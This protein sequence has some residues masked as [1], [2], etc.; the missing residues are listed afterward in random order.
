MRILSGV[1]N[2][3]YLFCDLVEI[4]LDFFELLRIYC[5]NDFLPYFGDVQQPFTFPHPDRF[6]NLDQKNIRRGIS[7]WT[8]SKYRSASINAVVLEIY[9]HIADRH[10]GSY[11]Y[12]S[13]RNPKNIKAADDI[14][15]LFV[16]S[17]SATFIDLNKK[18]S[19]LFQ[20]EPHDKNSR[21]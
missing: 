10:I 20:E 8:G 3:T 13:N 2:L 12:H 5:D 14:Y 9:H 16:F 21:L 15:V 11:V 6:C 7:R 1:D 19:Y 17:S 18:K 4:G